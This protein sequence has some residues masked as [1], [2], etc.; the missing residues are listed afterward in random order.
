MAQRALPAGIVRRRTMFGLLDADGWS[1]AFLKSLFWFLL[2]L[3]LLGYLPDRAYYFT[4][5]PTI[6]VG[7]NAVSPVNFCDA[8]NKSLPCPAPAGAVVP[9]E[10]S[11]PELALPGARAGAAAVQSGTTLYLV[12][13]ETASGATKDVLTTQVTT[14]GNFAQWGPGPALPDARSDAAVVSLSGVPYVIGGRDASGNATDTVFVGQVTS[15]AITGWKAA[16]DLKLPTPVSGA[17]AV[18]T[19]KGIYL[20]GGRTQNGPS[21]ALLRAQ[22]DTSVPPKLQKWQEVAQLPMPE[23]R[24]DTS[25]VTVGG[26]LFVLGGE[27][28]QGVTNE[29]FRLQLDQAGEPQKN[30]SGALIGWARSGPG[31]QALPEPRAGA[32]VF[33]AN[34]AMY[35]IG[36]R[37]TAGAPTNTMY[38]ATPAAATGDIPEWRRLDQT[39]LPEPRARAAIANVGSFAFLVGG[40]GPNGT[41]DSSFRANISPHPPFFRLGLFGATVPA[42]SIKGEIGQ[43]LGYLN[44][45]GLGMTNFVILVLIAWAFSHRR[46]SMRFLERISRG[47]I[48][49]PRDE[50]YEY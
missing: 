3:F 20:L 4:V 35:V 45:F 9:W 33:S 5:S 6:D 26:Y 29:V 8:A 7:Y 21:A 27:G 11:P 40:Q 10:P 48:R 19:A 24:A 32:T 16:D 50:E 47:R 15:G 49:A 14:T 28:P 38:W 23:P 25:A 37:D 42:L 13:G 1:W 34:S 41:V 44:A 12:G 43:Q 17:A 39:N 22:F 30:A 46:Q 2:I 36:G 18:A 31:G